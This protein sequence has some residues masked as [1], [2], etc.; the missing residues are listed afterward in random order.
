MNSECPLASRFWLSRPICAI[1]ASVA[2]NLLPVPFIILFIRQVFAWLRQ[3]NAK[4]DALVNR[5]ESRAESKRTT[6]ERYAFWGLVI[7]VAVPLPGTGAWTG[8]L[9]AALLNMKMKQAIP[10]I[11]VGVC[12]A[13]IIVTGITYGVI[14]LV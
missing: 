1:S 14:R 4:L 13:G 6:V 12:I 11:F 5:L 7:L 10:I 9:I 3:R 2:G 8:A